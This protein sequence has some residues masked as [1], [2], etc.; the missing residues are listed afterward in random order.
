SRNVVIRAVPAGTDPKGA[1]EAAPGVS[2]GEPLRVLLVFAEA[3]GSRPL[4]IRQERERLLRLFPGIMERHQVRVEV[5]CHAVTRA[6]LR[7]RVQSASGFHLVHWSGHG[8]HNQLELV[9]E[10]GRPDRISGEELARLFAEAGGFYPSLVFLSAC[11]SGALVQA[12][13][14]D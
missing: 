2:L 11:L 3:P 14:W 7:D 9:G 5:A 4:A 12:R 1:S 8:H 6:L 10:D 13:D